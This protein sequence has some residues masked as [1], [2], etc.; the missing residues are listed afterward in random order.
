MLGICRRSRLQESNGG[1]RRLLRKRRER[2]S[3]RAV[4]EGSSARPVEQQIRV[5]I[6]LKTAK[7]LG[8]TISESFLLRADQL[9]E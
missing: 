2:P 3:S 4:V 8:L 9:I 5:I 6:N 7:A 1:A